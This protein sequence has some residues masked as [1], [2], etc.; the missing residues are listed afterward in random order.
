MW[1]AVPGPDRPGH[2]G[3]RSPDNHHETSRVSVR[4]PVQA[5]ARRDAFDELPKRRCK[6][7][8][9]PACAGEQSSRDGPPSTVRPQSAIGSAAARS[10]PQRTLQAATRSSQTHVAAPGASA[11]RAGYRYDMGLW[12][13]VEYFCPICQTW[14]PSGKPP[15]EKASPA[16]KRHA[17]APLCSR[18]IAAT[19]S[20]PPTL[21][22]ASARASGRL[23]QI[24]PARLH[25]RRTTRNQPRTSR[26]NPPA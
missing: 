14:V 10:A 9:D 22:L 24:P 8:V 13:Q 5:R 1:V 7:S 26:T 6:A 3:V 16:E 11:R 4:I 19:P 21:T 15:P 12:R 2:L 23:G 17:I 20:R 18:Y 25:S